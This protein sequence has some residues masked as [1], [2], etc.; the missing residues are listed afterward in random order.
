MLAT[1]VLPT[2]NGDIGSATAG[3]IRLDLRGYRAFVNEKPVALS[4]QEFEL[5]RLLA[6]NPDRIIS[7]DE[8]VRALWGEV[9]AGSRRRLSVVICRLRAKLAG[10]RPYNIETVRGRGYGLTVV[11]P[12]ESSGA[13]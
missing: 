13:N 12:E 2:T 7:Y 10:A 4:F 5:L 6:S 11:G 8:L 9:A 1:A 3:S